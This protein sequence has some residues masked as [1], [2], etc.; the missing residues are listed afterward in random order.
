MLKAR[1]SAA[2]RCISET[3]VHEDDIE[4]YIVRWIR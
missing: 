4:E 3:E 1:K 2:G